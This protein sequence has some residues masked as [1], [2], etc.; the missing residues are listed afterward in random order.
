MLERLEKEHHFIYN[1][2]IDL[3]MKI[4]MFGGNVKIKHRDD[5][6]KSAMNIG[7]MNIARKVIVKQ[8]L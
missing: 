5:K 7:G 6:G 1:G 4:D 3:S 2:K 8:E